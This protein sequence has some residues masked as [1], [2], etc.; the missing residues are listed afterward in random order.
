MLY[1]ASPWFYTTSGSPFPA[2]GL[3]FAARLPLCRCQQ[4]PR[5]ATA[6][7]RSSAVPEHS[8]QQKQQ[9]HGTHKDPL[10]RYTR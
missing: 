7:N 6:H 8:Q 4:H 1:Q 2:F 5:V 3:R 9:Q 10:G